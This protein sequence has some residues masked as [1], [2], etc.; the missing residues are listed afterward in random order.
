MKMKTKIYIPLLMVF[1]SLLVSCNKFLDVQPKGVVIPT[2]LE[3][4]N[5]LLSAPLEIVRTSNNQV[6]LTDDIFLPDAYRSAANSYPGKSSVLAYDFA[7][8]IYD[9]NENDPDWNCAYRTIYITNTVIAGIASGGEPNSEMKSRI[10]GEA[11]VHRAFTY[12]NIVNEYAKHYNAQTA[13]SDLGVP[14][15]LTPDIN[16][17]LPR[18]TVKEVYAQIEKDLLESI[19]MLP[20]KPTYSYRPGKP[21]AYGVLA[22]MYLFMG[23]WAK[24]FEYA[25]KAFKLSNYIYDYNT[26]SWAKPSNHTSSA[27]N[28]Y[29][30]STVDKKD[31]V[32]Q[33][34][35][36]IVGSYSTSFLFSDDLLGQYENGDLRL[37]FGSTTTDYYLNP[38]LG[39]GIQDTKA[40]YDYNHA[41]I[42]TSELLLIRAEA[43]ARLNN[44]QPAIDDLNTLRKKRIMTSV[45][46]DITASTKEE[47]LNQVLR[48]RRLELAFKGMRLYDI[49]RL[50]LEGRNISI[51]RGSVT[52]SPNDPRLVLPIPSKVIALN[53]NIKQNPRK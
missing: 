17:L 10:L 2:T 32:F 24:A 48:Q 23:N 41:G 25:D 36:L 38:L 45:Y 51:K 49:K 29:P 33:K 46:T 53:P 42:T 18:S 6:Y 28:G 43:Q 7:D 19:N 9:S 39:R 35:L 11:L 4:Y 15:P 31:I 21:A 47:A 20:E 50:N 12:L 1:A 30:G 13:D 37:E 44:I 27:I 26:F 40:V 16:A 52:I 22:R 5:T 34:Y 14:M 3:D 8:D